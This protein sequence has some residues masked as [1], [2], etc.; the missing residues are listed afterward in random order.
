VSLRKAEARAIT[1]PGSTSRT[2]LSRVIST[3]RSDT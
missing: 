2:H 3:A 1:S